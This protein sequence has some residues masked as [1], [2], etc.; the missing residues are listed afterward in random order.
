MSDA[1]YGIGVTDWGDG[2]E[3]LPRAMEENSIVYARKKPLCTECVES[4]QRRGFHDN[5]PPAARYP[6]L[7]A[8]F[9]RLVEEIGEWEE[10]HPP[11]TAIGE[12][13][14]V[15]IVLCQIAHLLDMA[16]SAVDGIQPAGPA[17]V[18]D[19]GELRNKLA[20]ALRAHDDGW[21][22]RAQFATKQLLAQVLSWAAW[23]KVDFPATVRTKLAA[24][25]QRGQLHQGCTQ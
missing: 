6:Q 13:A 11:E 10:A 25:E 3:Y 24:D 7:M 9:L 16:D 2:F 1:P 4:V 23:A 20:R 17:S 12:L 19:V 5:P 14:D 21:H 18:E 15:Y 8:Q 22:L